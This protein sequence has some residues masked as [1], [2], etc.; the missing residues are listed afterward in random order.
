MRASRSVRWLESRLRGATATDGVWV[1]HR[2]WS[3]APALRDGDRL[4]VEPLA[5]EPTPGEI[6]LVRRGAVLVAHRL[7]A[8]ADGR[9]ITRG[10]ACPDDDPPVPAAMLCGRVV[11]VVRG[12]RRL[13]PARPGLLRRGARWLGRLL[14]PTPPRPASDQ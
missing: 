12:E 9:A 14:A 1:I 13:R 11:E 8:L 5:A 4:R 3:M 10:D 6:V 7:I 2:G